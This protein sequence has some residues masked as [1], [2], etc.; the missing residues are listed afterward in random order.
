MVGDCSC[1]WSVWFMA[2]YYYDKVPEDDMS[3][4]RRNHTDLVK[5]LGGERIDAGDRVMIEGENTFLL[6]RPSGLEIK[7]KPDLVAHGTDRVTVVDAKTGARRDSDVAQVKLYMACL[8][9]FSDAYRV[10]PMH[11]EV[12]YHDGHRVLIGPSDLTT[13]FTSSLTQWLEEIESPTPAK[14]VP[15]VDNCRFCKV[16]RASCPERVTSDVEPVDFDDF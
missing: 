16:S 7:G 8:P 11:G 6:R 4:W 5:Q 13:S 10:A 14:K 15:S 12:A 3:D 2:N 9:K 1:A